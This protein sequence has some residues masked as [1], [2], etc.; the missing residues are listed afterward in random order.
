MPKQPINVSQLYQRIAVKK[1]GATDWEWNE[2]KGLLKPI[3][4]FTEK[5]VDTTCD[6]PACQYLKSSRCTSPQCWFKKVEQDKHHVS[7]PRMMG[8]TEHNMGR[9]AHNAFVFSW[10]IEQIQRLNTLADENE[11][12]EENS[13][14]LNWST[15]GVS[16]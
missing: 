16:V 10:L 15:I 5:G 4:P 7:D 3:V 12:T 2:H 1:M 14:L 11:I 13:W 9:V 6:C 8:S